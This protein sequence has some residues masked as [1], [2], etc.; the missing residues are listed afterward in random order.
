MIKPKP[1]LKGTLR[2]KTHD[3][4]VYEK[5]STKYNYWKNTSV[6]F[7]EAMQVIKLF[8]AHKNFHFLIDTKNPQFLKGQ[9]CRG[10]VQGARINILPDGRK[11]D[12]AYSLFSPNLTIH[13]ESSNEHWDV[14]YMNPN[15]A[16][17]YVYTLD[18]K[19]RAVK[20]KYAQVK[21]FEKFYPV[22][23]KKVSSALKNKND[24]LALPM[25]T[26]LKT[27]MRVGNEI[28]YKA[29]GHKGLTTL[30]K[31]DISIKGNTVTFNYLAKDG[32]PA[33]ISDVFPDSYV[34]RL[35]QTL[36]LLK[37]SSFVFTNDS[38]HPLH[39]N[40][41]KMAFKKYCGTEF[42]PHIVR[43][44]Y[45]T[46]VSKD[47][48]KNHKSASREQVKALF[49]S[50]AEK[51]GHKRFSKKHNKW[52]DSFNVTI[53]H[54]IEPDLVEKVKGLVKIPIQKELLKKIENK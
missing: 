37:S 24:N 49:L 31:S 16:F 33:I 51:L 26:L 41:F 27:C 40:Q 36:K 28:Y 22:L 30:M 47:F 23:K 3:L 54:Y 25:Y 29:H 39:E 7:P 44:Y 4:K 52:E 20:I 8:R 19:A 18:K 43:S 14:I 13:D 50:I 10:K 45:A 1:V 12:K 46:S 53:H 32:V 15:G 9:L 35:K 38:G 2:I 34:S 48:L 6:K 11:L 17:S 5:T 21:N 42:Y